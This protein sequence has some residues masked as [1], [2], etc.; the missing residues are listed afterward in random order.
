MT[1]HLPDCEHPRAPVR[2]CDCPPLCAARQ[3]RISDAIAEANAWVAVA[4]PLI[5]EFLE[6][7]QIEARIT[8]VA[9]AARNNYR[10]T[11][12]SRLYDEARRG[13]EKMRESLGEMIDGIRSDHISDVYFHHCE[14]DAEEDANE[15]DNN[16]VEDGV[17][18]VEAATDM[19]YNERMERKS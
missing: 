9:C 16:A 15:A 19:I 3:W 14:N 10:E 13:I 17:M 12:R 4:K 8:T 5:Q 18:T 1:A 7:D 6:L 11:P 2:L